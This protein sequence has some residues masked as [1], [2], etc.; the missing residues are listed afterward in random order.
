MCDIRGKDGWWQCI[1]PQTH[2]KKKSLRKLQKDREFGGAP[3]T[4]SQTGP[5]NTGNP[6]TGYRET[7][8]L[9]PETDNCIHREFLQFLYTL[10]TFPYAPRSSVSVVRVGEHTEDDSQRS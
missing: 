5:A 3:R 9:Q 7:W 2:L 4:K 8:S 6:G 10:V 1:R